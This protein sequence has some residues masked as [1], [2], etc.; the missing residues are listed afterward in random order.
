MKLVYP[1][2][3]KGRIL[4]IEMLE[5]LRDFG[6]DTLEVLTENLSDGIVKGFNANVSKDIITFSKG[7]VK[8]KGRIYLINENLSIYYKAT[9]VDVLIKLVFLEESSEIDYKIQYVSLVLDADTKIKDNEIELGRFKLKV[10]AYL[11]TEYKDLD[12][13]TTEYNTIN[14]IN[15][16]YANVDEY[17]LTPKFINSYGLEIL[18]TKTNNI[19]DITFATNCINIKNIS[20]SL[21]IS[22]INVKLN[23]ENEDLTNNE[24]H[25]KLIIILK[26]VREENKYERTIIKNR[27]TII[28]D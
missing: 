12:D 25:K 2:F 6:R 11:R 24:I 7:I 4:K 10:G 15:V 22:Y 13:Y 23:E 19:W 18:K 26:R 5:N 14:L 8:Y 1:N 16:K 3:A 28:V 27:K 9:D 20:R 17:T 21:I